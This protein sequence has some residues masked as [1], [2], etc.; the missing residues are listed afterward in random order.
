MNE[1]ET[2]RG[3]LKGAKTIAVVGLSDKP[4]RASFGVSR[5]MQSQGYRILPVNPGLTSV[6]GEKAYPTLEAACAS[7]VK[8]DLVDVFRAPEYVPGIVDE[9][10]RLKIPYL[11][12]QEGVSDQD[13]AERAEAAGVKVVMDH[14]IFREHAKMANAEHT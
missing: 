4:D 6:L 8:V 5:Y 9:V 7:G 1:P 10:I 13:A 3:I 2:I 11:W 14:C 12:L